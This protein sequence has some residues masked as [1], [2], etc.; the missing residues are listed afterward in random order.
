[1]TG[2][3]LLEQSGGFGLTAGG[4]AWLG[5]TLGVEPAALTATRRPLARGCLDWTERRPHLAGVAGARLCQHFLDRGWILRVA[6]SRAVRVT[7]A[8]E[9]GLHDLLGVDAAALV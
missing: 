9:T 2:A 4:V 8:G 5:D 3:G 7:P 6:R 1:M